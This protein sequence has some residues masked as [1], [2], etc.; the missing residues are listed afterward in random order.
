M[1]YG[2]SSEQI[3]YHIN[4]GVIS[5]K[6]IQLR[7]TFYQLPN[8]AVLCLAV[9]GLHIQQDICLRHAPALTLRQCHG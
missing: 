6:P 4:M 2:Q 8:N 7:D 1:V 5:I 3:I 9:S